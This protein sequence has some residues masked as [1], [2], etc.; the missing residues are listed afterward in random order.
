[1][2]KKYVK[3]VEDFNNTNTQVFDNDGNKTNVNYANHVDKFISIKD[4]KQKFEYFKENDLNNL[5]F[6]DLL[7][8]KLK[9]YGKT[10][11]ELNALLG[12]FVTAVLHQHNRWSTV[13][14]DGLYDAIYDAVGG[15]NKKYG[16]A[17]KDADDSNMDILGDPSSS[18]AYW[19]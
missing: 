3:L 8:K 6:L 16:N 10:D 5:M 9:I 19:N 18:G 13:K 15:E 17:S 14:I 4:P 7:N 11:A 1:M 2:S 12:K